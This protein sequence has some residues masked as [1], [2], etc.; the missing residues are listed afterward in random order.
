MSTLYELALEQ[1]R[2]LLAGDAATAE[3][4]IRAYA[5]VDRD[6]QARLSALTDLIELR[7][8]N[9][10]EISR[11]W[12]QKE[13]R[14]LA[15]LDQVEQET[16]RLTLLTGDLTRSA[17]ASATTAGTTDAN[18]LIAAG[19]EEAGLTGDF[20]RLPKIATEAITSAVSAHSP[21]SGLLDKITKE[22]PADARKRAENALLI[23]VS[24]GQGPRVI[25]ANLRTATGISLN[26]SLLIARTEGL[27]AY[28]NAALITYKESDVVSAWI[29]TASLSPRTCPACLAMHNTIHP[30]NE[31]FAAHPRCRCAP[32]PYIEGVKPNTGSGEDWLREQ[33]DETQDRVLGKA[34]A[35]AW[36]DGEVSLS[37]FVGQRDHRLWGPSVYHQSLEDAQKVASGR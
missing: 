25:A 13:E 34:A 21:L 14:Y 22:M 37:D 5:T 12:L 30:K 17:V 33:D 27:R 20:N 26:R 2:A 3:R 10:E 4:L 35:E 32:R 1:R 24:T 6:I 9:G 18:T 11:A 15:L 28:R 36:R 8:M 31:P 19:A 16:R 23:G 29:W 7:K